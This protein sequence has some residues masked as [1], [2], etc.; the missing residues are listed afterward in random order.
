MASQYQRQKDETNAGGQEIELTDM[1]TEEAP[2]KFSKKKAGKYQGLQNTEESNRQRQGDDDPDQTSKYI[3]D[4]Y[5]DDED[6]SDDSDD[7]K[8]HGDRT[9]ME[10][11]EVQMEYDRQLGEMYKNQRSL[12]QMKEKAQKDRQNVNQ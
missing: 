6:D 2:K 1:S 3:E 10:I 5:G 12:A 9:M 7:D 11:Q 4:E 8:K